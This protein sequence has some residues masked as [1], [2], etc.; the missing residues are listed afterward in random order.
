MQGVFERM[1]PTS[2]PE[3]E[4]D[5]HHWLDEH[6]QPCADQEDRVGSGDLEPTAEIPLPDGWP[7]GQ[8]LEGDG[9]VEIELGDSVLIEGAE[10]LLQE[11]AHQ[12]TEP[13][14][15]GECDGHDPRDPEHLDL[16]HVDLE[17]EYLDL[18]SAVTPEQRA[19]AAVIIGRALGACEPTPEEESVGNAVEA[20]VKLHD[21]AEDPGR[22]TV[23]RGNGEGTEA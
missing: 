8:E 7:T 4:V 15:E 13:P 20:A 1:M 2:E 3:P 11:H 21:G 5:T 19:D 9:D 6:P 17:P 16:A 22:K 14:R 10:Q 23:K 12:P 18:R